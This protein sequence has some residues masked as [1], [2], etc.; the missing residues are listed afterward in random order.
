METKNLNDAEKT[1]VDYMRVMR[2]WE[3]GCEKRHQEYLR[4]D[5]S[6]EDTDRIGMQLYQSI[7]DKFIT[8]AHEPRGFFTPFHLTTTPKMKNSLSANSSTEI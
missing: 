5:L 2:D 1:L 4:G 7:Y 6:F 8:K 3:L